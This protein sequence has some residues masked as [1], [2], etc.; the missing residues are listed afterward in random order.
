MEHH[1]LIGTTTAAT[2]LDT[3]KQDGLEPRGWRA[4]VT[5][6][7][8]HPLPAGPACLNDRHDVFALPRPTPDHTHP[9]AGPRHAHSAHMDTTAH[10][11]L[12]AVV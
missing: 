3:R 4:Q 10:G 6:D 12:A 8:P 9:T 1:G 5:L 7:D 11:G 2:L